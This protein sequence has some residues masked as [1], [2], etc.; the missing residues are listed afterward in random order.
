VQTA[1][2]V[3][4]SGGVVAIKG[5]GGYHL[6]CNATDEAAVA[7]LRR[8][9]GRGDKPLAVM[10]ADLET[11]QRYAWIDADEAALLAGRVR[12]IVLLRKRAGTNLAEQVAPGASSLGVMLPYTPLHELLFHLPGE[13]ATA[14]LLVM[15]SGN[16]SEEP[17]SW[18]DDDALV[19]LAPL[20]DGFLLHDR[21]IHVPCDDSVVR[22]VQGQMLPIRRGR[23]YAPLPLA[24]PGEGPPLLAVGADLKSSFCL[25]QDGHAILSQHI[26]DMGNLPTYIAF[27][28]AVAH[29][30]TLFRI[31]PQ[32]LVCDAHPGYLSTRWA[33]EYAGERP[34]VRVQHHHAHIAALLAEQRAARNPAAAPTDAPIIGFCW[35]GTGYGSDGAIWGGETLVANCR[36]YQRRAHLRYTPL[37]GGDAAVQ[38]PYRAALAHLWAA[39]IGWEANLPPVAA[40][41]PLERGMLLHQLE[42]NL[43]TVQTS[44][45]GRLFDAVAAL[46]GVRQT[47]TYEG[48]AAV[49]LESLLPPGIGPR[50]HHLDSKGCAFAVMLQDGVLVCDPGPLLRSLAEGVLAG[51]PVQNLAVAFHAALVQLIVQV[52][53]TL[54]AET[55]IAQVGLSGGV[56]QNVTLLAGAVTALSAQGFRVLVHR[57]TPPND[58]G[59]A[60]GQAMIAAARIN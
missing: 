58:G 1:L 22:L 43:H 11:A 52:S 57:T 31:E 13:E 46:L 9:K 12:P 8:R 26:G 47:V 53:R 30:Q 19:R 5:L 49:E 3:L 25:A 59:I 39:G 14:P 10:A 36:S 41:P 32:L 38:R 42:N 4:A 56:F 23:G 45:M 29:L 24:F 20:V 51:A 7:L 35:D 44:S 6:A 28:H 18:R 48:Q 40:C 50:L 15:T 54:G 16:L 37:P 34:I 21:P 60:L 17:I 55:G 27:S 2:R 33:H